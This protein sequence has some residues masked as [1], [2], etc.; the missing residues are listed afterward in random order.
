[1]DLLECREVLEV[2]GQFH[3]PLEPEMAHLLLAWTRNVPDDQVAAA[4]PFL[5]ISLSIHSVSF[6]LRGFATDGRWS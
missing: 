1:M 5:S 3:I 4:H 2:F 6:P